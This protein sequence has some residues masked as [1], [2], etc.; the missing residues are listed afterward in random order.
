MSAWFIYI[1]RC[2]DNSL[3]TGITKDISRRVNEHNSNNVLAAK[4]TRGRRPVE[5]VYQETFGSRSD[6]A[7]REYEIKKMSRPEKGTINSIC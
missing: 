1:I 6:A 3:Y 5:L 4:Y 2:A 7:S